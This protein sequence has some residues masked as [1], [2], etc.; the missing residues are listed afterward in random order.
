MRNLLI[1]IFL[2]YD[3]LDKEFLI[4]TPTWMQVQFHFNSLYSS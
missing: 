4:K 3:Q 2:K 1:L